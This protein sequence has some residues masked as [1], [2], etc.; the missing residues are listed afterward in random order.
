MPAAVAPI[1]VST[2]HSAKLPNTNGTSREQSPV[3][4]PHTAITRR[5]GKWS[6][7]QPIGNCSTVLPTTKA[8]SVSAAMSWSNPFLTA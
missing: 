7:H 6:A 3:K 5:F 1:T 4:T 8:V 2:G